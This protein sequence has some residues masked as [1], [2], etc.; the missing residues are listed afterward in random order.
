MN[1][2]RK[3]HGLCAVWLSAAALL[4]GGVSAQAQ[5]RDPT[6]PPAAAGAV[7]GAGATGVSLGDLG[8]TVLVR[9]GK[10]YLASATRLYAEGQRYGEYKIERIAETEIWLRNGKELRKIPRFSGIVRR[11]AA[12]EASERP[13]P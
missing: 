3:L 13:H 11:A 10:P 9:D 5:Q 12:P 4:V 8:L 1:P 2:H 6:L 7:A